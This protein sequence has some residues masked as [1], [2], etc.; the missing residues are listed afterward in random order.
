[1]DYREV[2]LTDMHN[3]SLDTIGCVRALDRRL[4]AATGM[5]ELHR[6]YYQLLERELEKRRK[7]VSQLTAAACL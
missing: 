6:Q 1:M 5:D 7:E 4:L 3:L 2:L